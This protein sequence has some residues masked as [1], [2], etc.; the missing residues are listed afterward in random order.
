MRIMLTGAIGLYLK[1]DTSKAKSL[2][3]WRPKWNLGQALTKIVEW[4]WA[5]KNNN[6]LDNFLKQINEYCDSQV[7]M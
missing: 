7:E 6:L 2:L 5:Y 3:K 4:I 1:L